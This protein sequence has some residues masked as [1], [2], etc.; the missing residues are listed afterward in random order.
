MN[1]FAIQRLGGISIIVGSILLTVWVI[2]WTSLIP[3][4]SIAKD[5][6]ILILNPNWIWVTSI[7]FTSTILMIFGFTAVYSKIYKCTGYSGLLG[8]I[9]IVL[10]YILQTA[11]TS[12]ELFLYPVIAQNASSVF[13]LREKV[14]LFS[15]EFVIFRTS[16]GISIFLGVLLFCISIIRSKEFS[17]ISALLILIGSVFYA[18]SPMLNVSIEIL[19]IIMLSSGCFLLGK[20]LLSSSA[21]SNSDDS[22]QE[23]RQTNGSTA[24][25][26]K[27]IHTGIKY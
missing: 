19:S 4:S 23:G 5:F 17:T 11:L 15:S 21:I 20:K 8:F 18:I 24:R 26:K 3:I 27:E 7:V 25:V 1:I 10:A 16:L 6:S 22:L 13:L 12:W 9:F 2:L 14:I